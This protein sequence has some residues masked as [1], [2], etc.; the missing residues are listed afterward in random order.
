[1]KMQSISPDEP[2]YKD[3][4]NKV[5][6]ELGQKVDYEVL[7]EQYDGA[8]R[9]TI[10]LLKISPG[11]R[12]TNIATVLSRRGL[13]RGKDYDIARIKRDANGAP[14]PVDLRPVAIKKLTEA[15]MSLPASKD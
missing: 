13:V 15:T 5:R 3:V 4:N 8:E 14:I 7:S 1:M 12:I 2:G 11:I 10:F 9:K 6:Q